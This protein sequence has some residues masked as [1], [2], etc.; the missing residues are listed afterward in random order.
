MSILI[1]IA[2]VASMLYYFYLMAR[3]LDIREVERH[4]K[5]IQASQIK[6]TTTKV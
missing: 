2:G 5:S 4:E 1:G 6:K 3:L